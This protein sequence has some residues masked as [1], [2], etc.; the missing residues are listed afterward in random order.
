MSVYTNL[1]RAGYSGTGN[2]PSEKQ[3]GCWRRLRGV[4]LSQLMPH[5]AFAISDCL[6]DFAQ[7]SS[8]KKYPCRRVHQAR[9]SAAMFVNQNR[10]SRNDVSG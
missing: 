4:E 5:G 9:Y 2:L 8:L 6:I 7:S 1:E 10:R 3:S